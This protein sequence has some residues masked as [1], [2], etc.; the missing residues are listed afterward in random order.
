[1]SDGEEKK[2]KDK[3]YGLPLPPQEEPYATVG[4]KAGCTVSIRPYESARIDISLFYPCQPD[5]VSEVYESVKEWIDERLSA[6]YSE[7]RNSAKD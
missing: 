6:E 1:M 7:L 4:M 2:L 5:K 3:E